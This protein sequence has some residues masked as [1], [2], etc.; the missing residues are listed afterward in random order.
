MASGREQAGSSELSAFLTAPTTAL[1][2][3]GLGSS[4]GATL[5]RSKLDLRRE[6]KT[7]QPRTSDAG[8][9]GGIGKIISNGGGGGGDDDDDDD[10]YF[11]EGDGDG[12]GDDGFFRKVL[13][14][15]Y[16]RVTISAVLEEWFRSFSD[17]PIILRRA[18][19]MGLFSSAQLVR[20]CSMDVRPG[21]FR[22]VSRKLPISMS[23]SFVG[24][25]MA[26]P[27]F[28]QKLILENVL[29]ISAGFIYEV[30]MRKDRFM[31]ELDFA[32]INTL[33]LAAATSM[34]VW[35]LSPSRS[36]GTAKKFPWQSMLENLPNNVFDSSGPLRNYTSQSRAASLL[37]KFA[38]LSAV[39]AITGCATA[40][41]SELALALR[42]RSDPE[43][44]PSVPIPGVERSMLGMCAF[45]GL[46]AHLRYQTIGGI[47]RYLFD[48]SSFLWSYMAAST[49][50]RV[51]NVSIGEASRP[52]FQG[53]PSKS[54]LRPRAP[55]PRGLVQT[56]APLPASAQPN[57]DK[58][59]KRKAKG[60]ELSV[61]SGTP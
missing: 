14:Q 9:G 34:V 54:P 17:L 16:D 47:D 6:V 38:E 7:Q 26:D 12:D 39:G 58:P 10:D 20:F 15:L 32:A 49:M 25:L 56:P 11:D 40:G 48:H 24:R 61:V 59:K 30:R 60:F 35:M 57:D 8:G 2:G 52:W 21:I 31:E 43:F 29:A 46:H 27:A 18:V 36:Y 13:P 22:S 50:F 23:R 53:L 4:G 1:G 55:V 41:A 45:V 19:E 28:A 3:G 37:T 5:E 33:G 44:K 51:A 42:K